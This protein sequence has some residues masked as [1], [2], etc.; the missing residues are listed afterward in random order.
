MQLILYYFSLLSRTF[1]ILTTFR[2]TRDFHRLKQKREFER[3]KREFE[4]EKLRLKQEFRGE[5][6]RIHARSRL[7]NLAR[8]EPNLPDVIVGEYSGKL[9]L[10]KNRDPVLPHARQPSL[11]QPRKGLF[12]MFGWQ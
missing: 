7:V 10:F 5:Q 2:V 11:R 9:R 8:V 12:G 4:S 6:V 3:R 1:I